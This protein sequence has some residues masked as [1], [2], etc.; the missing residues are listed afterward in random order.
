MECML[1]KE[2]AMHSDFS[3]QIELMVNLRHKYAAMNDLAYA[4]LKITQRGQS[5]KA[6]AW[7]CVGVDDHI[8][9]AERGIT[10]HLWKKLLLQPCSA[11]TLTAFLH[12]DSS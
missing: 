10:R 11:S 6:L 7:L 12:C 1:Y 8:I 9:K 3:G 4:L 5:L 2:F